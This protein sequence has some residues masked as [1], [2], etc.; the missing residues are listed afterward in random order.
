MSQLPTRC[1]MARRPFHIAGTEFAT[2][3]CRTTALTRQRDRAFR[4]ISRTG[5]AQ[6]RNFPGAK[7]TH[8]HPVGRLISLC[9]RA[10]AMP[11]QMRTPRSSFKLL[12]TL[13]AL[14]CIGCDQASKRMATQLLQGT[15]THAYL[16]D[17]FRLTYAENPGAFLSLGANWPEPLR[18]IVLTGLTSA[19]GI[20]AAVW[21]YRRWQRKPSTGLEVWAFVL[22]ASG[23]VGNLI[24]RVFRDGRVVDFMNLGIGTLRSGIFNVADLQIMLG[25]ALLY[26]AQRKSPADERTIASA[27]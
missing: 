18:W 26:I 14:S 2:S 20:V 16:L 22:I 10:R 24:D 7:P 15:G 9:Y 17:T 8:E 6:I 5:K 13:V 12:M 21:A 19:I 11:V 3:R 27:G 4:L 25:G 23:G 1:L